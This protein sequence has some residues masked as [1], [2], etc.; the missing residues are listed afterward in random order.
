MRFARQSERRLL[1]VFRT[2]VLHGA[3]G[4]NELEH[5]VEDKPQDH[6][7]SRGDA[8]L[9]SEI[10]EIVVALEPLEGKRCGN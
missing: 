1:V 8:S 9:E 5:R 2:G 3:S 7:A 10:E 4:V 6:V